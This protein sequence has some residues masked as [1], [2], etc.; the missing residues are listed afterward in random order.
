MAGK[1]AETKIKF[2]IQKTLAELILGEKLSAKNIYISF[3]QSESE[4]AQIGGL[5]KKSLPAAFASALSQAMRL[6][7]RSL[8]LKNGELFKAALDQK[9]AAKEKE[10]AQKKEGGQ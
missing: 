7:I 10:N 3:V 8:P 1:E 4:S 9:E 2:S 5:I 6:D